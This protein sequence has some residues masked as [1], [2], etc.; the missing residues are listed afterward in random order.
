MKA[1]LAPASIV[2]ASHNVRIESTDSHTLNEVMQAI[3]QRAAKMFINGTF[4]NKLIADNSR[5]LLEGRHYYIGYSQLS[6]TSFDFWMKSKSDE[7]SDEV[8]K[9]ACDNFCE[10]YEDEFYS[11]FDV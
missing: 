10:S 9:D 5:T 2:I 8:E 1:S 4:N 6:P 3:A 7:H 11:L